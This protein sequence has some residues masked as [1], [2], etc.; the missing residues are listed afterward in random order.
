M[1]ILK[2]VLQYLENSAEKSPSK[3][4]FTHE[5]EEIT[6][7]ELLTKSKA[8]G[9]KIAKMNIKN[10]PVGVFVER[11]FETLIGFF[12]VLYSGN[13]YVPIDP[14]MPA[15]RMDII[16]E[17]TQPALVIYTDKTKKNAEELSLP[18]M[19]Y[20]ADTEIDNNRLS[21]IRKKM[22]DTDPVY[23]IF[24]SGSTGVPKGIVVSHKCVVDFTEWMADACGVTSDDVMGNQAPFY[25]DCSV[26]DIYLTLKL[27]ATTHII[28]KK[29]FMMPLKLIEFLD[30]KK[31]TALFWATSAFHLVASSGILS[32]KVPSYLK[33]VAPGGEAMLAKHLNVWKKALPQVKYTNLYGPT[34]ITV[35][36][37][38]YPIEREFEDFEAIPIGKA[39][40]NKEI[41]LLD[42]NLIPVKQGEPGEICVRGTGVTFGYYNDPEKTKEAFILN[43]LNTKYPE[44]IYRT[45]DIGI[46]KEDGNIVFQARRDGQ[47]KHMGY[48]IETGEIERAVNSF[49]M[50]NTAACFFDKENDRIVCAYEGECE[51]AEILAHIK[52]IIPKYMFPNIFMKLENMPYNANGKTD[53]PYLERIYYEKNK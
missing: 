3:T 21:D 52:A 1:G 29:F 26:K 49:E 17:K 34:E 50:I 35:D 11:S 36:C 25:F 45:G 53:R 32:K 15:Q 20:E 10:S 31:V 6:F 30:E 8:L 5:G 47:I 43:P 48:R 24:T 33:K 23:V 2:N 19:S 39:C 27:G 13:F 14:K 46:E 22:L 9:T 37:S 40:D 16:F 42:E 51:S 18:S 7:S 41:L 12:G 38:F 44:I 28:P 4:A